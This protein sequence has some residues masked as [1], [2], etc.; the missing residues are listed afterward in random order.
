LF[1]KAFSFD[2]SYHRMLPFADRIS[3]QITNSYMTGMLNHYFLYIFFFFLFI[4]GGMFLYIGA[5]IFRFDGVLK[6]TSFFVLIASGI[7]FSGFRIMLAKSRLT[8]VL[9]NGYIGF[10]IA[11]FFVLFKAPDLALTQLVV[12]TI[13]TTLFLLCFYFLPEWKLTQ[14]KKRN[15]SFR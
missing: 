5:F 10:S 8:A 12:E 9:I 3:K 7:A 2:A 4:V 11:L 14:T 6:I 1:P 15:N 13:S